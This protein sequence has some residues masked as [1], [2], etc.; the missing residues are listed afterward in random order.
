MV[1]KKNS[2]NPWAWIP[3][4]YFAEGLPNVIVTVLSVV[5]Y[6]QLGLTDAEVGLYTGWLALPWVI[7]PLWSPFIDLLK[8]KRWWVLTMQALIGAA[9]AGIAFSLHSRQFA[10]EILTMTAKDCHAGIVPHLRIGFAHQL[11]GFYQIIH[12]LVRIG[13]LLGNEQYDV[14]VRWQ[15]SSQACLL[16]AFRTIEM[17]IYRIRDGFY[18]LT[19]KKSAELCLGSQPAAAGYE[20]NASSA[21]HFLFFLP[22]TGR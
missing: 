13:C 11:A 16:L 12:S 6:M 19:G 8:T 21:V 9:L 2:R 4:L 1:T 7:K 10:F 3:T 22:D 5:M 17:G 18:P 15:M 14:L 20:R